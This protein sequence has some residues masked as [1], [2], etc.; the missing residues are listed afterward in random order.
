MN[1]L[2]IYYEDHEVA[3][4][5]QNP[6]GFLELEYTKS[7]QMHGFDISV[8]LPRRI[9]RHTGYEVRAFFENMLPEGRIRESLARRYGTN[10]E[11]VFGILKHVGMDCAGAFSI[12][13]PG[14]KG[15]YTKLRTDQI[16]ELLN[17][18]PEFPMASAEQ[19]TSLSLAGAQHKLPLFCKD[20]VSYL[21][22]QGAASNCILKLPIEDFPHTV[23]N[24]HFC[25]QLAQSI[26]LPT[27]HSSIMELPE[28]PVLVV[29]R[30]DREG[31][32]FHPRRLPQEDFCQMMALSSDIKYERDGGPSFYDC[33]KLIRRYSMQPAVD[34]NLLVKWAAF[35][36]CIGNN[37]AHA[38]NI[39]M[40]RWN[41]GLKL[42]PFYD[43][44]S[45]T[46]YG[47]RLTRRLAMGIGGKRNSFYISGGRWERF[48]QEIQ[49][50]A[51]TIIRQVFSTA[52]AIHTALS[53]M[54]A[55]SGIQ[56]NTANHLIQHIRQ[57]TDNVLEHL[58]S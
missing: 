3:S 30:Y 57:R 49:I 52:Q 14:T 34:L 27:V 47:R 25:L 10:R 53:G 54:P 13:G 45:T 5:I 9:L 35:N 50:P 36:L 43:L 32:D 24:E 21:P 4:L 7:W 15:D 29:K 58:K 12:G 46:Y 18:L 23:E 44:L 48:A 37:D 38:K 20:G 19:Q 1:A 11:N 55:L 26:G 2:P 22:R 51:R 39:S 33:A 8:S 41:N 42:A 16:Q 28:Y 6:H 31:A 17:K 40:I 56:E